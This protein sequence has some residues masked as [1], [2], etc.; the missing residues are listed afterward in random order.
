MNKRLV[1]NVC[2]WVR[3]VM[4]SKQR[5]QNN[6]TVKQQSSAPSA[7][8]QRHYIATNHLWWIKRKFARCRSTNN[9][10]KPPLR[11]FNAGL[12]SGGFRL[13]FLMLCVRFFH[14]YSVHLI[15][16]LFLNKSILFISIAVIVSA[17][18]SVLQVPK[19]LY[20]TRFW[21]KYLRLIFI[22]VSA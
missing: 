4:C 2:L 21:E 3:E 13:L 15:L 12:F 16:F 1:I 9:N 7:A 18:E 10:Q 20:W 11:C 6:A 22:E 14:S 19:T 5:K 8:M 17:I